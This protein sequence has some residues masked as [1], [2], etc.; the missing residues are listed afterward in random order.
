M[1][2][3]WPANLPSAWLTSVGFAPAE[4]VL[5]T[6]MDTGP[7]KVRRVSSST[8]TD[9]PIQVRFSGA[10]VTTFETWFTGT[11]LGG[12][13]RFTWKHPITGASVEYRFKARPHWDLEIPGDQHRSRWRAGFAL[14]LM[15]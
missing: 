13:L 5:R 9:V 6:Q 4:Q 12:A 3:Y 2:I 14:E 15:P 10:D 8:P 11:L 1:A 7:A